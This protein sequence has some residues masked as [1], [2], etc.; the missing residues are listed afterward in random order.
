MSDQRNFGSEP[1]GEAV[2]VPMAEPIPVTP[3]AADLTQ[4]FFSA[5]PATAATR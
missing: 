5:P 2:F 1:A 4:I 3:Q